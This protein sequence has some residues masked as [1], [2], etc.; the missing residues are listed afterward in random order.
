MDR[1]FVF[2]PASSGQAWRILVVDDDPVV[3]EIVR[4][5]LE[6]AGCEVWTADSGQQA[7]EVVDRRGLPHLA[8]VDIMMPEMNGFELCA[9]LQAWSDLPVI[10]LTAVSDEQ[11]VV[12]GIRFFAEDYVTKPFRGAELT[13]RVER[14]LRRIGDFAYVLEPILKVDENLSI[15]FAHRT[16]YTQ[17]RIVSL[18]PLETKLL[19]ILMRHAARPLPHDFILRRLWPYE[20]RYEDT[21][22]VVVYRL[23]RRI[24]PDPSRPRY[25]LTER[26]FGYVF[27]G[28][29]PA[30]QPRTSDTQ[31]V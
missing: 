20:E 26:D 19:H 17:S 21:L 7:L 9:R 6:R 1:S 12:R 16:V 15:D 11:T 2:P 29:P 25:I 23:R 18:S 14:V 10:L 30:R 31:R 4:I 3:R 5:R 28:S 27:A 8:I 13:A 24:E 22:R